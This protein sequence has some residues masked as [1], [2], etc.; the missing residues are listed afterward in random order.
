MVNQ[1]SG[2]AVLLTDDTYVC[3]YEIVL[4]ADQ[5]RHIPDLLAARGIH[6][7]G[8]SYEL[9][10]LHNPEI[11]DLAEVGEGTKL[12]LPELV[13]GRVASNLQAQGYI[14]V[15][16]LYPAERASLLKSIAEFS[17]AYM[18]LKSSD[19]KSAFESLSGLGEHCNVIENDLRTKVL[20]HDHT[21][22]AYAQSQYTLASKVADRIRQIGTASQ[23][24]TR[25]M[26]ELK[27]STAIAANCFDEEARG[28]KRFSEVPPRPATQRVRARVFSTSDAKNAIRKQLNGYRV[29]CCSG[30][31]WADNKHC[32]GKSCLVQPSPDAVGDVLPGPSWFFWA[33][34]IGD[35]T[36]SKLGVL[37]NIPIGLRDPG[38]TQQIDL[39]VP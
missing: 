28:G 11:R 4:T 34:R 25:V 20:P 19:Q 12:R 37:E 9:V 15:V 31:E 27:K 1:S 23:K 24:D 5:A 33:V 26:D 35:A 16:D 14:A 18:A 39:F 7:D 32:E 8:D 13:P 10:Y 36:N 22:L 17:S 3:Y 29:R 30:A 2:S 6:P 21:E 38:Q